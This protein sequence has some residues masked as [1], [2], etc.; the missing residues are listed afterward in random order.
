M[1][2]STNHGSPRSGLSRR[3]LLQT[4]AAAMAVPAIARATTAFA[5]DKLAG[6][7]EVVVFSFGGSFTEGFRKRVLE[8]FSE[9][10]GIKVVDVTADFSEPQVKAMNEAGRVDWDT[11]FV[12]GQAYPPM[13]QAGM[14]EPIDY[15]LWDDESLTGVPDSAR[16]ADAVA[17]FQSGQLLTYDERTFGEDGPK[18]WVDFWNVEAFPG[19]RGLYASAAKFSIIFA[20]LADGVAKSDI[21]PL[22]DDKV[23]RALKKLDEIKPHVTKWW[24]AGGEPPQLL[25]NREYVITSAFANRAIVAIRGQ[26]APIRMVWGAGAPFN[27]T[28]WTVLKGGPNTQNAQKLVAFANRAAIAAG[29]TEGVGVDTLNVNQLQHLPSDLVPLLSIHP[30]NAHHVVLE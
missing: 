23:D 24:S 5:Q 26:D 2:R 14:F 12:Q 20:L 16:L 9:V 11:A 27:R 25:I 29:F 18:S 10:T 15:T 28:Y 22:T 8:P 19:P 7:G 3:T 17:A 30:E 21:W 4:A 1:S 13:S 6:S